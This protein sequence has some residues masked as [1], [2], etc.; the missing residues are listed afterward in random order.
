M[1]GSRGANFR[2]VVTGAAL[3]FLGAAVLH[4]Y[5]P[6]THAF[7]PRCMLHS[8]TGLHCPGCGSLRALSAL[9]RGDI[10]EA[11]RSNL[12]LTLSIPAAIGLLGLRRWLRGDWALLTSIPPWGWWIGLALVLGFGLIR[13]FPAFEFLQP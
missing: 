10:T 9:A 13:N 3:I 8:W 5:P 6:E 4:F 7:Y 2:L 11:L 1:S 12:L